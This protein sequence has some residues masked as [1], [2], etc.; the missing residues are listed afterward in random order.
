MYPVK[1]V[2]SI[3]QRIYSCNLDLTTVENI[4]INFV[5][6]G[7]SFYT[8]PSSVFLSKIWRMAI[9]LGPKKSGFP[10]KGL[11]HNL[12]MPWEHFLQEHLSGGSCLMIY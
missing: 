7:D 1:P 8:I 9:S 5:K 10:P 2:A 6:L 3:I 4:P 11:V 12:G